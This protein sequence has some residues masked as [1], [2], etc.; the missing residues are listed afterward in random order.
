MHCSRLGSRTE[1]A[2]V[3]K[4]PA[5][6]D[7]FTIVLLGGG[8]LLLWLQLVGRRKIA[9]SAAKQK[10]D[11]EAE[12]RI[13]VAERPPAE[14]QMEQGLE[15]GADYGAG[16]RNAASPQV[17]VTDAEAASPIQNHYASSVSAAMA[18]SRKATAGI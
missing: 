12:E 1:N 6:F 18:K 2:S 10:V 17:Q 5:L 7:L 16:L 3:L 13:Q 14:F 11:P 15:P 8:C 9:L 4:V